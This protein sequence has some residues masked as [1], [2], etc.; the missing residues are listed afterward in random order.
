MTAEATLAEFD[1][2][3]LDE[4]TLCTKL[5]ENHKVWRSRL[6]QR[7]QGIR[8]SRQDDALSRRMVHPRDEAKVQYIGELT[9]RYLIP[10]RQNT[11]HFATPITG[12]ERSD[13]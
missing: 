7:D 1:G 11:K 10:T 9:E 5:A 6:S 2:A 8:A 4:D 3:G 12:T 13:R